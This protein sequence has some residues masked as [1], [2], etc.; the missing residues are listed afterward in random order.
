MSV[1]GRRE[2]VPGLLI[3]KGSLRRSVYHKNR[4]DPTK[5]SGA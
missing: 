2:R 3:E 4:K 5:I 1:K